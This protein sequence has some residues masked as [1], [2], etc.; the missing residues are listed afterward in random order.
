[1]EEVLIFMMSFI[2]PLSICSC[3]PQSDSPEVSTEIFEKI[4][5]YAGSSCVDVFFT[6]E[7]LIVQW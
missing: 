5:T 7:Y 6:I 1:M 4:S 2:L 3:A